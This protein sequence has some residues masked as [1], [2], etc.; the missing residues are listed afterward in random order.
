MDLLGENDRAAFAQSC[1]KLG[2]IAQEMAARPD[3]GVFDPLEIDSLTGI[4]SN[5]V[6]SAI[7]ISP[8]HIALAKGRR[9]RRLCRNATPQ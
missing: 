6:I 2:K 1:E 4:V 8:D 3:F 5:T 9:P 7:H